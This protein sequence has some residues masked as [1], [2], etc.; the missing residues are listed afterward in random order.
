M[1]LKVIIPT[2]LRKFT[3]GAELVEVDGATIRDVLDRLEARHPGIRSS[4]CDE[5]GSLKRFINIYVDGEDVRFLE[6]LA[7]PVRDGSEIAIVP[8]ISGG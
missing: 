6:N 7:T 5:S 4:L 8:A 1:S 3:A 2:P